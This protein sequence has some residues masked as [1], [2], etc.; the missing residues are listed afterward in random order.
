MVEVLATEQ[1]AEWFEGLSLQDARAVQRKV[2]MLE[3]L[4]VTLD[5]PHS[6]ALRGSRHG[7]RELRIQSSGR[8]LRVIYGFDPERAAIL[9]LGGDKTGDDRFYEREI[10]AA[11]DLYDAHL[12]WRAEQARLRGRQKG[13]EP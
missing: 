1:Y 13:R 10:P 8:P 12:A 11:D 2:Q 9:L 3:E 7:L 6:S 5:H 4:G